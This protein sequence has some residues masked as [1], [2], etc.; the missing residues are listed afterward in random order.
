[1]HHPPPR[2]L[3]PISYTAKRPS[4]RG[5][6]LKILFAGRKQFYLTK[7]NKQDINYLLSTS[8]KDAILLTVNP[9]RKVVNKILLFKRQLSTFYLRLT[10]PLYRNSEI[11][12]RIV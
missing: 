8:C 12:Q 4:L 9:L 1:M 10:T 7:V 5:V 2:A 3:C 11:P 6:L